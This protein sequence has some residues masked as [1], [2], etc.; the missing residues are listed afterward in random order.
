MEMMKMIEMRNDRETLNV[1][2]NIIADAIDATAGYVLGVI[3]YY[4]MQY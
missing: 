2:N 1:L 3:E 4:I